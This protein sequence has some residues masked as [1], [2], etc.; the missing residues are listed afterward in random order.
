MS[1]TCIV[2]GKPATCKH[3]LIFGRGYR[4]LADEDLLY[5][6]LCD[7][8]HNMHILKT[9]R[10]HDNEMAE[11]LSK[12]LGQMMFEKA[13]VEKGMTGAEAHSAFLERYGKCWISEGE[14]SV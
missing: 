7:P 1:R 4:N 8:C 5:I 9:S 6:D 2:C 14:E 12:A 13:A 11:F 3:H 10:I